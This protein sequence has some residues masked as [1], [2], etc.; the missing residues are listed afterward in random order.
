MQ[1][2]TQAPSVEHQNPPNSWAFADSQNDLW[3][4][5]HLNK[6]ESQIDE[7]DDRQAAAWRASV[8]EALF[9]AGYEDDAIY[10]HECAG[11]FAKVPVAR[12][13]STLPEN[14]QA[15]YA[16]S[17]D[18][19][20]GL[21]SVQY[22]CHLRICPDC[23]RREMFRQLARY[24]PL[25]RE[26]SSAGKHNIHF[27]KIT[28][29]T[30][31]SI[32]CD[33]IA[34]KVNFY[35][36]AAIK[37]IRQSVEGGWRPWN[38]AFIAFEFGAKG[39]KL[40]FHAFVFSHWIENRKGKPNRLADNWERLSNG[41]STNVF[42]QKISEGNVVNELIET[43]K[44]ATKFW[45]RDSDGKVI[46]LEP[47][48]VV[49]LHEVLKGKRRIRSYGVFYGFAS[50]NDRTPHCPECGADMERWSVSHWLI[51]HETGYTPS[52]WATR[53]SSNI[54]NKSP[55]PTEK[56]V[57]MWTKEQVKLL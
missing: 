52:D 49:R 8:F 31:I 47:E 3:L 13:M 1:S 44:Y 55:P 7:P 43:I 34:D 50:D 36:N 15:V 17:H 29:T 20:H 21:Q 26:M 27:R 24:A 12:V 18:P 41:E 2:I 45:K 10:F 19:D 48:T 42:I 38:G 40:H 51:Y 53:F 35:A 9:A 37:A 54:G 32:W 6:T 39:L 28:L 5:N 4:Q 25:V 30:P 22:T 56:N 11:Q 23:A 14:S 33:D 46:Y 16:C 57:P